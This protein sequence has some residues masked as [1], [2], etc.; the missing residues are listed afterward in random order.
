MKELVRIDDKG[1]QAVSAKELHE[2]LE[3]KSKFADWFKNRIKR[4]GYE[5]DVDYIAVTNILESG[6]REI[7]YALTIDC[8]KELSM[9][10]GNDK[11]RLVRRYFLKCEKEA[12]QIQQ[13]QSQIDILVQ[14]V[15]ILKEHDKRLEATEQKIKVLEAKT[16]LRQ[17]RF[18][19]AGYAS[20]HNIKVSLIEAASLGRAAS[21]ICK[22]AG[23]HCDKIN[24]P[25]FGQIKTYPSDILYSLFKNK[26]PLLFS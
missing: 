14:N 11:G 4:Y 9:V 24:D 12:K 19:I 7:D 6:G 22:D 10:E 5:E 21:K 23:I 8:A 25:R 16:T 13:P 15:L 26:Y 3:I 2:E 1:N 17:D 18:A 20:L